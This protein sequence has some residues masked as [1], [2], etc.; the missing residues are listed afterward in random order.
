MFSA[1]NVENMGGP[2]DEA[3]YMK[4]YYPSLA[5]HLLVICATRTL[6]EEK[7]SSRSKRSSAGGGSSWKEGG[8][9][10]MEYIILW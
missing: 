3:R 6:S 7:C 10:Y 1:C 2:G 9:T 4:Y 5:L 8:N